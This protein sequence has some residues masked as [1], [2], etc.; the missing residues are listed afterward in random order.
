[1]TKRSTGHEQDKSTGPS[2]RFFRSQSFA[3]ERVLLKCKRTTCRLPRDSAAVWLA[4]RGPRN[5]ELNGPS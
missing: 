4:K 3:L 1:M 2:C 5:V